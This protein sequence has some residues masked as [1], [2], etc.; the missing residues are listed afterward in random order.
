MLPKKEQ[1]QANINDV[2]VR[3]ICMFIHIWVSYV[4][5]SGSVSLDMKGEG[6]WLFHI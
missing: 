6:R 3:H 2:S 4:Y 1:L 5:L